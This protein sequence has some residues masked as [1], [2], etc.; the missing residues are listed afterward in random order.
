MGTAA[1]GGKRFKGRAAVSGER[2]IGG[3]SCRQ[4]HNQASCQTGPSPPSTLL[5][6]CPSVQCSALPGH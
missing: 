1:Y 2:P 4:Q 3:A 5:H 6:P